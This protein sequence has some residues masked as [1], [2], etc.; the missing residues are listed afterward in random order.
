MRYIC[1]FCVIFLITTCSF[2][3][4][5]EWK[6]QIVLKA[7]AY[8]DDATWLGVAEGASFEKDKYD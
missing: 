1:V 7:G 5:R 3:D 2:A 6:I 4:S 8:Y